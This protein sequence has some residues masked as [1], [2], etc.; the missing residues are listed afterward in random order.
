VDL[1]VQSGRFLKAM[2]IKSASTFAMKRLQ[3]I[4]RFTSITDKVESSYLVY[5]GDDHQLSDE[6]LAIHYTKVDSV[7]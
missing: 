4:R 5:S 1:L 3:G 2:E 6:V 7:L